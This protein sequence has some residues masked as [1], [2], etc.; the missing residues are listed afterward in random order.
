M[1]M[2][3]VLLCFGIAWTLSATAPP[4]RAQTV[5]LQLARGTCPPATHSLA[6]LLALRESGFTLS[7]AEAPDALAIALLACVGDPDPRIRDGVVY[8][9]LATW[10]RAGLLQE[11]TRTALLSGLLDRLGR[12][13]P[14]GFLRPFAALDLAEVA[15]SDRIAPWMSGAA[16][17]QLVS[18]ARDYL[19]SVRD[20]RGFSES[21]G[22]R[23]GVAHGSDL[24]LQLVLNPALEPGQVESLLNAVAD[25]VAPDG[26]VFYVYGE[27]GRLARPV[28]FARL[29]GDVPD[30]AWNA[31]FGRIASPGPLAA[32]N[33]AFASQAG[34][35]RRHNTLAFLSALYLGA[36]SGEEPRDDGF[37]QSIEQAINAVSGG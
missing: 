2:Q 19:S 11:S 33:A 13:D 1:N 24:A 27:P 5:D 14:E 16:R 29:R 32:W 35:A 36:A 3:R 25:Q 30:S 15:R 10:L 9:G 37:I 22:W 6:E 23:H 34:L 8:E 26:E 18:A 17:R 31:W 12:E 20:Y 7:D 4:G 28:L 21:E